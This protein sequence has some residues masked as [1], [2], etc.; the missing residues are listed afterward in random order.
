MRSA[1]PASRAAF[2]RG[3]AALTHREAATR[4]SPDAEQQY[5][6]ARRGIGLADRSDVGRLTMTGADS[7]DLLHR[8][9]TQDLLPLQPGQGAATVLTSEKG[10]IVDLL[11]V[12]RFQAHL[13]LLTSPGNQDA[14]TQWVDKYT[15]IEE[16]ETADVTDETGLLDF[17]GPNALRLAERLG[18]VR[19]RDLPAFHHL[20]VSL[21][22]IEATLARTASPSGDAFFL[23]L[24]K[25]ARADDAATILADRAHDLGL[26][27]IERAALE[28]LR[29]EAG[30]PAFGHEL[31]QRFNPLEA[32]L[33]WAISFAKGCYIGQE[34]VARLD[35]YKKV[36]KLLVGLRLPETADVDPDARLE[37][38]GKER[39]FVTSV[40]YSP[41]LRRP[42]ALAYVR[43]AYAEPG[44]R[45]RLDG[46]DGP[47]E[48]EVVPL[49]FVR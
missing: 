14:V 4:I 7:L 11:T 9:S 8:L 37:A 25:G 49:P 39:G 45:L 24:P 1:A 38:D 28:T 26:Q 18:G 30:H 3:P 16:T 19:A 6:A 40:G 42:I 31:D 12:Y 33:R 32:Q 46:P 41:A 2:E 21:E 34:V 44:T 27:R 20:Q 5:W 10:R 23:V 22:D 36:Q 35:T 43:T 47:V 29:V 13:L 48:A 15:I 17:F